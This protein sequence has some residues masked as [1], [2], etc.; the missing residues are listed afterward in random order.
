M[1]DKFW[2]EGFGPLLAETTAV[3]LLAIWM[4]LERALKSK[5][6]AAFIVEP[7]QSEAGVCV[8]P[9]LP[10]DRRI[11][12]PQAWH[13]VCARRSADWNVPHW[14]I[15]GGARLRSRA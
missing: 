8:P 14:A 12:V 11:A 3:S 10:A 13:A 5:R 1:S 15:P 4:Q 2:S 7:I 6:F 9:R